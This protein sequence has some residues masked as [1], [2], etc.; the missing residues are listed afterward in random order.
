VR[1]IRQYVIFIALLVICGV[2]LYTSYTAIESKTIEQVNSEQFVHAEQ[3]AAGIEGFFSTYNSSLAFLSVNPHI[4]RLDGEGREMMQ[5]FFK[6]HAGEITSISRVNE[7][8]TIL[9]TYPY[10]SLTGS[11]ISSQTHM[12]QVLT[13]RSIV[14]GD[15]FTSVQGFRSVAFHMPVFE[16]GTFRGSIAI[17]VPFDTLARKNLGNIRVLDSGHAWAISQNGI[18]LYSPRQDQIDKT[19]FDVYN[20]SPSVTAIVREAVK[21]KRGAGRYTVSN[22]T[23]PDE[24]LVH[25]QAIYLPVRVGDSYWSIIVSTP[26]QEILSTIQGFRNNLFV[27]S[28]ILIITLLFF[29]YY[30]TRARGILKEEEKRRKAEETLRESEEFNRSLVENL[31]D[32]IAI[33]DRNGLIKFVNRAGLELLKYAEGDVI[34]KPALTFIAD[35]ERE[36]LQEKMNVRLSGVR[37]PPYE[38]DI[39]AGGGEMISVI[40]Q[41]VP[42][43]F[44][45]EPVV[46]LL[47]TNITEQR[48]LEQSMKIAKQKINLMNIVALHDIHNK[49]IG[50]QGYVTLI[51]E[52][53]TDPQARDFLAREEAILREIMQQI[54]YTEEYQKIG[55]Q[56]PQWQRLGTIIENIRNS[57]A[58]HSVSIRNEA[59]DLELFA[60]PVIDRVF[61]HLIDNS[62]RHGKTVTE[63]RITATENEAGCSIVYEDDGVGIPDEKRKDLFT[64]GF[65]KKI[66]FN[67][68]FVHDILDVYGMGIEE[69]GEPGKGVRFVISVPRE[70]YRFVSGNR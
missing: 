27:I 63:I 56:P 67:L 36:K 13:S 51:R 53:V 59:Q 17:L 42:I 12:R 7:N 46:L 16:N 32:I 10:E 3:A 18:I 70:L 11:D 68:F 38:V 29:T 40:L 64:K 2:L 57:G 39:M 20:T 44:R 54:L 37:E 45:N 23:A 21:G 47:M 41:A 19:A 22:G 43:T 1:Y 35:Y 28:A 6:N 58:G 49:V 52:S 65:G 34:G 62:V 5:V 14:V 24:L 8:G 30:V 26:E 60:D 15:V 31:P 55:Q 9:Y 69:K 61:L 50:I 66:G 48:K 25:Y 33:Y 4:T